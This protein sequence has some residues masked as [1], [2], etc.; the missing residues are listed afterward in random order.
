MKVQ[1]QDFGPS[2]V[3]RSP[4]RRK[5]AA[6]E[7]NLKVGTYGVRVDFVPPSGSSVVDQDVEGLLLGRNLVHEPVNV[8]ELLHVGRDRDAFPGAESV[9]LFG[10]FFALFGR[11]GRDVNLEQ[12]AVQFT[13]SSD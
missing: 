10:G 3:L 11:S 8:R 7:E 12:P 9:E 13:M 1:R 2:L 6:V 5:S 4:H